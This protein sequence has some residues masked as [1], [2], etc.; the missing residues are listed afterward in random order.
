MLGGFQGL[1]RRPGVQQTSRPPQGA[2]GWE[3]PG[4]SRLQSAS[5]AVPKPP[6]GRERGSR[7]ELPAL[8]F[9]KAVRARSFAGREGGREGASPGGRDA[10][11]NR[12]KC[13]AA[14]PPRCPPASTGKVSPPR[15]E[16]GPLV[17]SDTWELSIYFLKKLFYFCLASFCLVFPF[18]AG[19]VSTAVKDQS[20]RAL[21]AP[22]PLLGIN[23][24]QMETGEPERARKGHGPVGAEPDAHWSAHGERGG[25]RG[26]KPGAGG[27][28]GAPAPPFRNWSRTPPPTPT[29]VP[30]SPLRCHGALLF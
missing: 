16:T 9:P 28:A 17:I 27:S 11:K 12:H 13:T 24:T 2:S 1:L 4:R 18:L 14:S 22:P 15:P 26:A 7:A 21:T 10:G 6:G 29:L 3:M 25:C 5:P 20:V 8:A 19:L 30:G 23:W